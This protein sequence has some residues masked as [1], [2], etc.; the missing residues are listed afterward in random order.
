LE[1]PDAP[2]RLVSVVIP[3]F[4]GAGTIERTL[5]SV[6]G[7]DAT[8]E[9]VIVDDSSIDKTI[10]KAT[11]ILAS[12]SR[13][14]K[15]IR[16]DHNEGLSATLN[17]G[18]NSTQGENI[19]VLHQDCEL[20]RPDWISTAMKY[21]GQD[22]AV[23]TGYYGMFESS[24]MNLAKKTFGLLR[25]QIHER[26]S[27]RRY[28]IVNFS[29]G[30]CDMYNAKILQSIGGFPER[31]RIAG[32][33]LSVSIRFQKLGYKILKLYD[34]PVVQRYSGRAESFSGNLQKEFEFGK[35]MGGLVGEYKR[36][37]FQGNL[38]GG[39]GG[40]RT[41]HR[42]GQVATTT[43]FVILA[44]GYVISQN[45]LWILVGLVLFVSRYIY[46]AVIISTGLRS[47]PGLAVHRVSDSLWMP[48]LG[49]IS[50]PIYSL[51]LAYGLLRS[52]TGRKI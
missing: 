27:D 42:V 34:L 3:T 8:T 40:T 23:V 11:A 19:L 47:R 16:H 12:G 25:R 14:Y 7:Q 4:N 9:I 17:D 32:E 18:L 22:I 24:D 49:I 2:S 20:M 37:V 6:L 28:E 5:K 44:L 30:K 52:I 38:T 48:F 50:D 51:G 46:Y 15:V 13:P 31:Y 1:A 29:E 45:F 10:D 36:D 26:P 43:I 35:A 21:M 41:L 39:Y 33:D